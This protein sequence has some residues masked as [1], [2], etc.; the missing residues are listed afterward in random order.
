MQFKKAVGWI[1]E[2]I[3]WAVRI[4]DLYEIVKVIVELFL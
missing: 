2:A 3:E 4:Y 1:K